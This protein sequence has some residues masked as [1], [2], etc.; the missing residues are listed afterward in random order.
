M[1]KPQVRVFVILDHMHCP[2]RLPQRQFYTDK[3]EAEKVAQRMREEWDLAPFC[4]EVVEL[5]F[6]INGGES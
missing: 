3:C 6:T 4:V 2:D 1:S 5:E